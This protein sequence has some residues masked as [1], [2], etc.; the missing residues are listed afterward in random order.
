MNRSLCASC[1]L[2][3]ARAHEALHSPEHQLVEHNKQMSAKEH[4]EPKQLTTAMHL[5]VHAYYNLR[6]P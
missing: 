4:L 3:A 5:T 6:K 1:A 2:D